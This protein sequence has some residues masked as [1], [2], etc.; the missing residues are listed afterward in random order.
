MPGLP[1]EAWFGLAPDW[2]CEILSPGTARFDRSQ[3]MPLYASWGVGHAW[4][5]DP[6]LE[7]LEAYENADGRWTLAGTYSESATVRI[8]PFDAVELE[9]ALLWSH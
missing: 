2:V 9:L 8:A 3:K 7:L 5:V 4:L 6:D 1:T